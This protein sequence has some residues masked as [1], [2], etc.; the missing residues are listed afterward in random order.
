MTGINVTDGFIILLFVAS[1]ALAVWRGFVRELLT[2]ITWILAGYL[3][4]VYGK[5]VGDMFTFIK[6]A[7]VQEWLGMALI[8]V[9]V[10]LIGGI[11]KFLVCRAF[12]IG[13]PSTIDRVAG[14]VFGVL[15]AVAIMVAIVIAMPGNVTE[16]PWYKDSKLIHIVQDGVSMFEDIT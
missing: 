13:G 10:L 2:L 9:S 3:A 5:Q 14:F 12:S 15:R 7:V 11:L 4:F 6:S 1:I 16:Q 8:F